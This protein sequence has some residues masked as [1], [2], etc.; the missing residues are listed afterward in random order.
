MKFTKNIGMIL[1]GIY[2]I[3]G[4]CI[5]LFHMP[6]GDV[7]PVVELLAGIFILIGK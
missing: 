2:L 3:M 4:G 7:I 1:L 5:L 6:F